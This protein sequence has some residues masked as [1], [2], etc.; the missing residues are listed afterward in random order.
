MKFN[1]LML[2][3]SIFLAGNCFGVNAILLAIPQTRDK[4]VRIAWAA[5]GLLAAVLAP[6]GW[7]DQQ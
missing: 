3:L 2:C 1:R 4:P 7:R 5:A 6:V